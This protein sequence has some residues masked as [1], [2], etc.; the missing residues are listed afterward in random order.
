[1]VQS[2]RMNGG[3][4]YGPDSTR[5]SSHDRDGRSSD[6]PWS[7]DPENLRVLS[8][9]YAID[10]LIELHLVASPLFQWVACCRPRNRQQARSIPFNNLFS[11]I[12]TSAGIL[13]GLVHS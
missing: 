1:M 11:T 4:H 8:K 9:R 12:K 2:F 10:R 13:M 7:R 5:A 6:T 3:M